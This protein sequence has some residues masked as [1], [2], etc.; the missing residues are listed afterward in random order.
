M[1]SVPRRLTAARPR[2]TGASSSGPRRESRGTCSMK[3][4]GSSSARQDGADRGPRSGCSGRRR[5]RPGTWVSQASSIWECWAPTWRPPPTAVRRTMGTGVRPPDMYR[6]LAAWLASWSRQRPRKSMNMIS[7]T[8][9]R[10]PRAAP[11]AAPTMTCSEMGVSRTRSAPY[12]VDSPL[13]TPKT[14]PPGSAMSSPSRTTRSS[15]PRASSRARVMAARTLTSPPRLAGASAAQEHRPP[16]RSA[17]SSA[18]GAGA[19]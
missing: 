6:S 15:A 17:S 7:A 5:C 13:V 18:A 12:L 2:G 8:G 19:G 11:M 4:D 14:P 9:R 16:R 3:T 1:T 10:P